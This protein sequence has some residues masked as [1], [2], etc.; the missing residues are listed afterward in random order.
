MFTLDRLGIDHCDLCSVATVK[1]KIMDKVT[2]EFLDGLHN[3][4]AYGDLSSAM[5]NALQEIAEQ[6]KKKGI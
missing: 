5:R 4:L 1:G 2:K 3:M 6:L